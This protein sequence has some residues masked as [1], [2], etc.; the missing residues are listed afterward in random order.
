M[1]K[2]ITLL[3]TLAILLSLGALAFAATDGS[4]TITLVV[5]NNMV[6][7]PDVVI[8]LPVV[9][10]TAET[11]EE[12]VRVN[13]E[14]ENSNYYTVTERQITLDGKAVTDGM[15]YDQ[16]IYVYTFTV[17]TS[18]GYT[19]SNNPATIQKLTFNENH[20]ANYDP[21]SATQTFRSEDGTT[22]TYEFTYSVVPSWTLTVPDG[23]YFDSILNT[24]TIMLH[25]SITDVQN[26]LDD[27]PIYVHAKHTGKFVNGAD[28]NKTIDFTLSYNEN[29]VNAGDYFLVNKN[30]ATT[31]T[32]GNSV[33]R[34]DN[35][36][37]LP[38]RADIN[39]TEAALSAAEGGT[40]NT[41]ISYSSGLSDP[42]AA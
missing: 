23:M 28:E 37:S 9:G 4:Q 35:V 19:L 2:T 1:K 27:T 15:A 16:G 3:I 8:A 17:K 34:A 39:I 21:D 6:I 33:Y 5:P 20:T 14:D 7:T 32:D 40:Y 12:L 42:P 41:T 25:T 13:G 38:E 26:M 29:P 22:A 11:Y 10:E 24:Y 31:S 36:T 18:G 30:S